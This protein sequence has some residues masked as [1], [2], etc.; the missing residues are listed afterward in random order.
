MKIYLKLI[1]NQEIIWMK[2]IFFNMKMSLTLIKNKNN[3]R[4]QSLK[5]LCFMEFSHLRRF[6]WT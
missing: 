4:H 5:F 3:N 2:N 6:V 1:S